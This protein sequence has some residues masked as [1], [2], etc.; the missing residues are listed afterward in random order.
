MAMRLMSWEWQ[1]GWGHVGLCGCVRFIRRVC[2]RPLIPMR[3]FLCSSNCHFGR[4]DTHWSLVISS[5]RL[6]GA[7][8]FSSAN[9]TDRR[10]WHRWARATCKSQTK[11]VAPWSMP[12]R[13]WATTNKTHGTRPDQQGADKEERLFFVPSPIPSPPSP[14]SP[15][16]LHVVKCP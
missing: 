8:L 5:G 9:S 3:C 6:R 13:T 2:E 16:L 10:A 14:S 7:I 1:D 15:L 11:T 12:Q 4:F